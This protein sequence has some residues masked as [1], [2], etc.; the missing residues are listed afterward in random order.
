MVCMESLEGVRLENPV[1]RQMY[2]QEREAIR[3]L[4]VEINN[5]L[6]A[7]EE[8]LQ[9]IQQNP[10]A[11]RVVTVVLVTI[12]LLFGVGVIYPLSFLPVHS[13]GPGPLSLG[14]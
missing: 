1:R 4:V 10:E 6:H 9:A 11:S 12:L 5:H 8:H 7:V 14:A 3:R 2:E 13:G